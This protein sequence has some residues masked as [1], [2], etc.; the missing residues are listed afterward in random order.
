MALLGQARGCFPAV[1]GF[2]V[3]WGWII[4]GDGI[5]SAIFRYWTGMGVRISSLAGKCLSFN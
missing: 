4:L 2:L 3:V 1:L 5:F